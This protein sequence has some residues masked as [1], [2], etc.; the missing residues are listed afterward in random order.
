MLLVLMINACMLAP[1]FWDERPLSPD[2]QLNHLAYL[3]TTSPFSQF[4]SNIHQADQS[5]RQA[6]VDSFLHWADSTSGVPYIED[7]TA[8][9]LYSANG[10]GAVKVAG[11]F[12]DWSPGSAF[13]TVA[14]TNFFY[15][16]HRFENDARLDYKLIVD[17][18]WVLDPRNPHTC[19]GGFGPNSELSMQGYVQPEEI[20][21]YDIPHG[22]MLFKSF[23]DTTQRQTRTM[24]IYLPAG[25]DEVDTRYRT[26]YFLDGSEF[27]S[28]GSAAN[29]LDYLIYNQEIPPIIAVF[30][31][32]TTRNEEYAYDYEFLDMFMTELVPWIDQEYRTMPEAEHRA[33]SGVSLGGLTSLL[34]TFNK[35]GTFKNC[36]AFSPAIQFGDLIQSYTEVADQGTRIYMDAGTYEPVIYHPS[37]ELKEILEAKN[38]DLKWRSW[39]EG[40]SWGAW[41][42]HLDEALTFFWPLHPTGIDESF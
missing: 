20:H 4:M 12:N 1:E 22:Q 33:I 11:D 3:G 15:Q 34:F 27:V 10:T 5:D 7:T 2:E 36:G 13:S 18:N 32:P 19:S 28:L 31:D 35:P 39:H 30:T 9:F 38:W 14:G 21:R 37:V 17:G 8:F 16:S 6:M 24:R 40:H 29:V 41:R 26:A 42:A 23:T 25:Y